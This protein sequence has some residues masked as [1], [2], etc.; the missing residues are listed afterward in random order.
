MLQ[1]ATLPK[2]RFSTTKA[3]MDAVNSGERAHAAEIVAGAHLDLAGV[4]LD[5]LVAILGETFEQGAADDRIALAAA[6]VRPGHRR[7]GGE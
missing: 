5:R 1:R 7:P 6:I 4:E 2:A 3:G